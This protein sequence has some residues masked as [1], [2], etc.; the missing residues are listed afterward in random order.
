M[1][2][3]N[4]LKNELERTKLE[5]GI[6]YE[7]SNAMRTTLKLDEI[8]YI[9]LTGVTAHIGLGFNRALLFLIN[10][11]EG[12]IEGKMG[13]GPETG[14]E[15]NR[16]W[17]QIEGERMDLEDLISAYKTSSNINNGSDSGFNKQVQK[18]RF[19]INDH[20][21]TLLSLVALEGMPLHLTA[22]TVVNYKNTPIVQ[23]LKSDEMVLIPLK[24]KNKINGIIVADNFINREPITKDDIRML[25]MLANQ[26]GLAI[27]NS[28]LYEK[29]LMLVNIDSL[30]DLWNHGYFQYLLNSE[31]EKSRAIQK[32]LSLIMIDIDYFKIYND[33][34]GHQAGD[35]ILKDLAGLLKNQSRKMDFVCR[36]GGE[37][38][39][40][41]LPQTDKKEA[42]MIAE[43]LR[44]DIEKFNFVHEDILPE[45]KLTVSLGISTFPED[46][47]LPTELI[48]AS[49]KFLY[50][51]KNKGRNKTCY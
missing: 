6:L 51:A 23:M 12:L 44:M 10:D 29:T 20:N 21:E 19:S 14:D 28:Q 13:I 40:I 42:I 45:K 17:S 30:T 2:E 1:E 31:L 33:T 16:I 49:D 46:G 48:S 37:E 4:K 34:L 5:L 36:Y 8:L 47:L 32:Q 11:K 3:L 22:K 26:A 9:I 27:E 24:A 43:R 15:A 18:L 50:Q 39:A 25:N 7:I 35:K 38:F 41:I